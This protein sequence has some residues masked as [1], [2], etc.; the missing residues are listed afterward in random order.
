MTVRKTY[1]VKRV[2]Y[3]PETGKKTCER[4]ELQTGM[5]EV[6]VPADVR[7][8]AY[9]LVNRA[10]ARW[11]E[12]PAPDAAADAAIGG[13][14]DFPALKEPDALLDGDAVGGDDGAADGGLT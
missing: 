10:P 1:K 8:C 9:W 13:T 6:G 4:E 3:D 11:Q 5:D 14:V 12:H 2:E 7:A